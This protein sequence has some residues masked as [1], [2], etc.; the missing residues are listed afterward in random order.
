MRFAVLLRFSLFFLRDK[1]YPVVTVISIALI[2]VRKSFIRD[3]IRECSALPSIRRAFSTYEIFTSEALM[4]SNHVIPAF[5]KYS[6]AITIQVSV[7]DGFKRKNQAIFRNL[8]WFNI[9]WNSIL[10]KVCR[11]LCKHLL[12]LLFPFLSYHYPPQK[13]TIFRWFS[14]ATAFT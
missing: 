12:F 6:T 11:S 5:F 14:M 2:D 10:W 7:V 3:S 9:F 1:A 4:H 13:S 8:Y